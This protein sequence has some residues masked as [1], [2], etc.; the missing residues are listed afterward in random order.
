[1][2]TSSAGMAY[3]AEA[4]EAWTTGRRAAAVAATETQSAGHETAEAWSAG[5]GAPAA[6]ARSKAR[7]RMRGWRAGGRWDCEGR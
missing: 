6:V 2:G 5:R 7:T 3:R 1:M 4:A